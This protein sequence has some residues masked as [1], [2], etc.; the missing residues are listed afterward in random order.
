MLARGGP[1]PWKDKNADGHS[2][3]SV[4]ESQ[5]VQQKLRRAP[6]HVEN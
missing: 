3:S 6:S 1:H 2:A 5:D 4:A